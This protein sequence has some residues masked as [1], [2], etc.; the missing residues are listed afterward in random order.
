MLSVGGQGQAVVAAMLFHT[1]WLE[2]TKNTY[3][4]R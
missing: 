1:G 3:L 2:L 4:D